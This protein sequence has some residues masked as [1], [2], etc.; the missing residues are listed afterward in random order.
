VRI[1]VVGLLVIE[2]S[3]VSSLDAARADI[4]LV[5]A[6]GNRYATARAQA[7]G[8]VDNQFL[9]APD[10]DTWSVSLE[11]DV[12]GPLSHATALATQGSGATSSMMYGS[13]Q[14]A[15]SLSGS[16]NYSAVSNTEFLF[17]VQDCE[18]FGYFSQIGAA[19]FDDLGAAGFSF[20][21]VDVDT[22][23]TE[24]I[25]NDGITGGDPSSIASDNGQLSDGTYRVRSQSVIPTTTSAQGSHAAP[26]YSWVFNF[27]PCLV[28]LID[29]QPTGGTVAPGAT[30]MLHVGAAGAAASLG[31]GPAASTSFTYQWRHAGEDLLDGGHVSGATAATLTIS[32]F[33]VADAGGY[34]VWVS[35]GAT[36]QLSSLAVLELPEAG[37]SGGLAAGALL[38]VGIRRS[39]S[40]ASLQP[41]LHASPQMSTPARPGPSGVSTRW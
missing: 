14:T 31:A 4:T 29:E 13:G 37:T 23:H 32:S 19:G 6:V 40:R 30:A 28:A 34:T 35:D 20:A 8:L 39:R 27:T 12:E 16:G 36:R 9:A 26:D 18:V 15:G 24:D 7:D 2:V 21:A 25:A 33:D 1:R 11:P 5:P 38:L 3:L 10:N 17:E 22:G 41:R